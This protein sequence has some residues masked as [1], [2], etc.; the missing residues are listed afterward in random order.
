MSEHKIVVLGSGGVG[1]SA[2][3]IRYI[4]GNFIE[5]VRE[6]PVSRFLWYLDEE[7]RTDEGERLSGMPFYDEIVCVV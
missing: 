6:R 4:Q 3:T 5:K 2:V 1:K 7:R